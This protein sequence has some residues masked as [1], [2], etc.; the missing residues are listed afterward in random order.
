[1]LCSFRII[2]NRMEEYLMPDT[3]LMIELFGYLGSALVV[4]SM[5][6]TSVK[7]LRIVNSIGG[8]IF[9]VYALIIR[10]YPTA[11]M[12][13]CLIIINIYQLVKLG[14]KEQKFRLI[15]GSLEAGA[16]PYLTDYYMDDINRF[17]PDFNKSRLG[18]CNAAYLV[19]YDTTPAGIM[20]GST[21][22][23]GTFRI[24]IDYA[25]PAYRDLSV[26]EFL[27]KHLSEYGID[28]LIFSERINSNGMYL[29]KMGFQ[30]TGNGYEKIL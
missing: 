5:L 7:K 29:A 11:F 10:S 28:K 8:T 6:M 15:Q 21:D 12:N 30:K 23:N 13:M 24:L 2:K 19:T 22:G 17:F 14:R 4:I 18:E 3:K 16:I 9:T 25:T 26:G 1:M 27:Y 20:I